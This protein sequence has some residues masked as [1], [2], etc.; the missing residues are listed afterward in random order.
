MRIVT[1]AIAAFAVTA[2]TASAAPL[3]QGHEHVMLDPADFSTKIDNPYWPMRPGTRW[4][5]RESTPGGPLHRIVVTVTHRTR[6]MANGVTARAVHDKDTLHG[7][8]VEDTF[9]YYAQD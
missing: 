1:T 7:R 2:G 4:I 6:T 3:P 9:D 5:S 8:T